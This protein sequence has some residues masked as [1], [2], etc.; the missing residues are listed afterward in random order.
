MID[1]ALSTGPGA[2]LILALIFGALGAAGA[3]LAYLRPEG[4]AAAAGQGALNAP[5]AA[6]RT[7]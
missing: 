6:P 1:R 3:I 4:G 7:I 2:G 5:G